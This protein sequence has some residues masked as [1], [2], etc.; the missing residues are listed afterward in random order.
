[1]RLVTML[2]FRNS[3]AVSY[4]GQGF[5]VNSRHVPSKSSLVLDM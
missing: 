3:K 4:D 5:D 2:F 1:M